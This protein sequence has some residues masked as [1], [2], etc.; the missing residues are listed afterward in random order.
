MAG[1]QNSNQGDTTAELLK[2]LLI[3]ELA[4]AGVQQKEIRK[5]AGC[6]MLRVSRIAKAIKNA[7]PGAVE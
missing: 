7:K 4:K 1:K 5:I 2:D 6:D 3:V